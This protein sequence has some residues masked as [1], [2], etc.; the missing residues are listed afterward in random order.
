MVEQVGLHALVGHPFLDRREAV[1]FDR[2][3]GRRRLQ[4][5]YHAGEFL[6]DDR[7]GFQIVIQI[8]P[9]QGQIGQPVQ[10]SLPRAVRPGLGGRF[11]FF[12]MFGDEVAH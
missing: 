1:D 3:S 2:N 7:K 8:G 6:V 12:L 4:V 11:G 9:E 10:S 5:P